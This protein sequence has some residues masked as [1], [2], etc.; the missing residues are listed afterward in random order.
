MALRVIPLIICALLAFSAFANDNLRHMYGKPIKSWPTAE[1]A[2]GQPAAALAPLKPKAPLATSQ[3]IELGERLFN[4]PLLSRDNSV[5]CA[6][7]HFSERHFQDGR[8]SATG[9]RKQVGKRN[10]PPIFG[11]DHWESFFWDGRAQSATEQ[12]LKP[13]ENPIEM[14]LPIAVALKRLNESPIYPS[15]FKN[16]YGRED[17]TSPMLAMALV[18]FER[19]IP[20]P[21]SKYQHF[22]TLAE[23][24]P[25]KAQSMLSDSELQGLHLFRTKA[26]CMTC[27]EGALLS[28]N[29][30]HVTGFHLY[31]RRF[32]DLGRSEFTQDV[33]DI[34]KFRTPSLLGVSNTGPWMHN[35]LFTQFRPMIEQYN[36][37]GFR[38][39]ARGSKASDPFFPVTTPLIE[40][41][42]LTEEEVTA[43]VEFLN[44]L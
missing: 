10:T 16:A 4:D 43:L 11:I 44:I 18:A 13:I 38:P 1:T 20:P 3:Q 42:N 25:E 37:G 29:E 28:D 36:A 34:G 12:A 30:F 32:E 33:K 8:R 5:S 15:L 27:H 39:K 7:C 17:I 23:T 22:I 41:L 2:D 6:S 14:D 9:V 40:P 35:G 24:S 26:Q 19:T 21:K 31:G